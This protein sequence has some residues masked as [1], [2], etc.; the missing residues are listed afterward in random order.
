[1][2]LYKRGD[3][4]WVDGWFQGKRYQVST[5][6]QN[7]KRARTFEDVFFARLADERVG[8]EKRKPAPL[9][10]DFA[11]R[12]VEYVAVRHENKP[13]TVSFYAAKL[14]RLLESEA[15]ASA[16][17]DSIDEAMI[18]TYIQER[19]KKVAPAT[20]NRELAT[21]RRLLR[22]AHEWKEINRVP[23]IRLLNGERIRDFVLSRPIEEAYLVACP[24][25]LADV[26]LLILEAGLRIGEVLSLLWADVV[27]DPLVGS[28]F[29]YLRI[30]EGKSKN[31]RR[32]IP[33]TDKAAQMLRNRKQDAGG[34]LVFANRDGKRYLVTSINHLHH[35]ARA[36]VGL[37]KDFVIHSLRH[38]MLTRLGESGVD[39]FTIMRIAGHSSIVVSQRYVHPTP[40][41]VERAFER[42][43]L[44]GDQGQ[45]GGKVLLPP[46]KF[47]TLGKA[48][49]VSH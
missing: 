49:S 23:K 4:W 19:R 41:A 2:S 5:K 36:L 9:F 42:L 47:T 13:Q 29:G 24:Q 1:M 18:E 11:K 16:R 20:V 14:S 10:V 34:E 35:K 48:L 39:A 43:Q 21:L 22:L 15:I 27:L 31:A 45:I 8:I 37:G 17:L 46:T 7:K 38:T 33:L 28:R 44:S 26:T 12:F 25:P 40:E 3:V 6:H 32:T 30:R